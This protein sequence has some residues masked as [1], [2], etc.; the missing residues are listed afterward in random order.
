MF[1]P[2]LLSSGIRVTSVDIDYPGSGDEIEHV[3]YERGDIREPSGDVARLVAGAD[4]VLL[5][6]P[7]P[8]AL[9]A[10]SPLASIMSAGALLADTLSVK[11]RIA[12]L[13][14][15]EAR[16]LEA[17]SLNP[18][19]NP[20]LGLAGRPVAAV[21]LA[22]GPRTHALCD[23]LTLWGARVVP[24]TA[25]DHDRLA[26]TIQALTHSTV[27]AFGLALRELHPNVEQLRLLATPPLIAMLALL[28][29]VTS[30]VPDVYWDIQVGNPEASAARAELQRS[31]DHLAV[32]TSAGDEEGFFTIFR[33]L[34]DFLTENL[35]SL[36]D[37]SARV[38]ETV[39]SSEL[40]DR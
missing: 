21:V 15:E 37:V 2:L 8:V 5:A 38:F 12:S 27:L 29:R 11:S 35:E 10:V 9:A 26:A 30:G 28:S 3:R 39:A 20:S 25:E 40:T 18:M 23:L 32:L 22:D 7:E 24:I 34:R 1:I 36:P 31:M 14:R 33:E 19:F 13:V 17:V 6:V 4:M 16:D